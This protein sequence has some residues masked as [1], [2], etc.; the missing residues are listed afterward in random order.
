MKIALAQIN[1]TVGD[2]RGN[3]AEDSRFHPAGAEQAAPI[4]S[5]SPN[6]PSAAIL[7]PICS[8]S[9][10]SSPAPGR[11]FRR[12]PPQPPP[13]HR[14]HLRIRHARPPRNRQARH[15]L[16]R[17]A[18]RRARRVRS[19]ED[20]AAFLRCLR[21][22][23]LLRARRTSSVSSRLGGEHVALTICEDAWND[24]SFWQNR[25][26]SRRSRRRAH[27]R[28]AAR[29]SS[30]SP[31]RPTGAASARPAARCSPPSRAITACPVLMV[32]QVGGNDSLVFDGSSL[33]L[34]RDGAGH[35][36]GRL[37]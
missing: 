11:S 29:S 10:P 9:P 34:G 1:P 17:A 37:V 12:S 15:E 8:R 14:H 21:R 31:P 2:F 13:A 23:A 26:Y 33:V 6:S 7:R 35:R 36:A 32:N 5:S 25:L 24:K 27:A 30:T 3:A 20:A 16:R 28:R 22:A 4:S 18:P 19:V